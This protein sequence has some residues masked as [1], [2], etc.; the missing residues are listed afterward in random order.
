MD[1]FGYFNFGIH[2]DYAIE[3][4]RS[5]KKLIVEVNENMP[6]TAGNTLLH[7]S[8]VDALVEHTCPLS[9]DPSRPCDAL[10]AKIGKIIAEMIPNRATLQFGN[11]GRSECGM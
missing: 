3:V 8:E 10:D 1:E 2:G 4:A 5:A 6:R 11:W 7:A 9:E